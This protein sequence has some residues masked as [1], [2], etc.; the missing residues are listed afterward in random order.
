[1]ESIP[2][3]QREA[4]AQ[5]FTFWFGDPQAKGATYADR[6][7]LWFGK[8]SAVDDEIRDRFLP[9]YQQ[10][11]T[12][13]LDEWQEFPFGALALL[14]LLDQFSRNLF[15]DTPQAFATDPQA[16]AIAESSIAHG[17]DRA[18][19][20]LMRMFFYLPLEH[21]EDRVRQQRSIELFTQLQA[22]ERELA[23]VL[24]YAQKH[25]DVIDRFG[26]FPHRNRI[27]GRASTIEEQEFLQQPGSSF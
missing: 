3:E 13:E 1:M 2:L 11:A 17:F 26:R 22:E 19:P 14:L 27:L 18:V 20:P 23:D 15:R 10:A 25:K 16:L 24:D 12:G 21:S 5:I 8:N 7:K 9:W 4:I 6:R